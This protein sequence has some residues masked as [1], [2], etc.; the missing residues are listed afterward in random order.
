MIPLNFDCLV[1]ET[2]S[3]AREPF[4]VSDSH[5]TPNWYIAYWILNMRWDI[6]KSIFPFLQRN[7]PF[8]GSCLTFDKFIQEWKVSL[9]SSEANF[10]FSNYNFYTAFSFY[11]ILPGIL[12][13]VLVNATKAQVQ[14]SSRIFFKWEIFPY[15]GDLCSDPVGRKAS[16]FWRGRRGEGTFRP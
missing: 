13:L 16:P 11:I 1:E 8:Q 7:K 3:S 9:F 14:R 12:Y 4:P 5:L 2:W 10:R 15:W 6:R